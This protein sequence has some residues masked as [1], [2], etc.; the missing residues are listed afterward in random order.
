MFQPLIFS[1]LA[2]GV[3]CA[4]ITTGYAQPSGYAKINVKARV[5]LEIPDDWA[6]ND[7]E[8]RQ[9][10]RDF[11]QKLVSTKID[12]LAAL[13]V[14]SFPTPS[15]MWV[16]VSFISMEPPITQADLRQELRTNEK[17]ALKELSDT[18]SQEMPA[19]WSALAKHGIKEVGR[20]SFAVEQ[21]SGQTAIVIR[22]ARTSAGEPSKTVKVS[23]Y[24][25]VLGQEKVLLTLS[26]VDGDAQI[27]SAHTRI[28]N[29]ISIR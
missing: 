8:S 4:M 14:S 9:Q 10:V 28:K 21:L 7:A 19:M 20:P 29:S 18:F 27:A 13:S 17:R 5:Q 15:K 2:I 23:Q 24:H 22:Y 11:A 6:I 12:H 1:I 3:S 25:V 26:Y 16:R